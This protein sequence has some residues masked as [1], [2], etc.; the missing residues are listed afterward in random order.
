MSMV[1]ADPDDD[2]DDSRL[3]LRWVSGFGRA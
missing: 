3:V 2:D 1:T